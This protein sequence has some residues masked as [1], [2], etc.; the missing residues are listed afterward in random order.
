[1]RS[2]S[3]YRNPA[4][5]FSSQDSNW[6]S[7][8]RITANIAETLQTVFGQDTL[9]Y[10]YADESQQTTDEI[11]SQIKKNQ[12]DCLVFIDHR[13]HPHSLLQAISTQLNEFPDLVFYI[14]GDFTLYTDLWLKCE[15][16]LKK[17]RVSFICASERQSQLVKSFIQQSDIVHTIPFPTDELFFAYSSEK[18]E[19]FR[20]KMQIPK[21]KFVFIYTGR[22]S[23]QKNLLRLIREF[24]LFNTQNKDTLLLIAGPHDSIGAPFFDLNDKILSYKDRITLEVD[25]HPNI[26]LCGNLANDDLLGAYCGADCFIS[27]STHHDEDFGMSVAEALLCGNQA[28][29][30]SWGGFSSF[31]KDDH[32]S[33]CK[34]EIDPWSL[35]LKSEDVQAALSKHYTSNRS[36]VEREK[37]SFLYQKYFSL[38]SVT[39]RLK[40]LQLSNHQQFSGF[41]P[42]LNDHA[43]LLLTSYRG[44]NLFSNGPQLSGTYWEV[45]KNYVEDIK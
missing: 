22:L 21:E 3:S 5:I 23:S 17:T 18:R 28:I 24:K 30:T 9:T 6:K 26:L 15:D 29:L 35:V 7:C 8:Q 45:Y 11:V 13:P 2:F 41:K 44:S 14:Y 32:V 25:S 42:L 33:L 34:V 36:S 12:H 38:E 31:K 40:T 39:A 20:Q 43:L 1:M 19:F 16:L 10:N 37:I 4:I 27:L